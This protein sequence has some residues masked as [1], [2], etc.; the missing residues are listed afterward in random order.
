VRDLHEDECECRDRGED[1][2]T[3]DAHW[4]SPDWR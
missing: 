1:T 4:R 2:D 3:T